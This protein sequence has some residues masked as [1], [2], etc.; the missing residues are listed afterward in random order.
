MEGDDACLIFTQFSRA[1]CSPST[2]RRPSIHRWRSYTVGRL[3]TDKMVQHFQSNWTASLC[4]ARWRAASAG[5]STRE[6][7]ST[8]IAGGTC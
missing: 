7:L 8:T 1:G 2:S 3:K 6:R 5:T 4:S